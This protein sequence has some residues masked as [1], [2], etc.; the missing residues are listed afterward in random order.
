MAS[1]GFQPQASGKT[2]IAKDT[3]PSA[4]DMVFRTALLLSGDTGTA[5]A[6]VM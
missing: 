5:E 6:A 1:R 4:L 2:V 3:M